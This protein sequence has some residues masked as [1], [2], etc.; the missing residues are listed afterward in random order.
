M[1]FSSTTHASLACS[2]SH[3]DCSTLSWPRTYIA[4]SKNLNMTS[5][6]PMH[7]D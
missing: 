3:A 5:D 6:L 7:A 4:D 1:V 2:W